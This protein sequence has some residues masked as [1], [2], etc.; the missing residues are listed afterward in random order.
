MSRPDVQHPLLG[1]QEQLKLKKVNIKVLAGFQLYNGKMQS[2][3]SFY[4]EK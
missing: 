4:G 1:S 3:A 2:I